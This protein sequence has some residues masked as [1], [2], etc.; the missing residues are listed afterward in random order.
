VFADERAQVSQLFV[1][2]IR[3]TREKRSRGPSDS[4]TDY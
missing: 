3:N 4:N 1:V 2:L